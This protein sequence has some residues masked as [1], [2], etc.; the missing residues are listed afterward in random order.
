MD[1]PVPHVKPGD[2]IVIKGLCSGLGG[3]DP[4]L[5]ILGDVYITRATL[6]TR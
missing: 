1:I 5:G 2:A 6:I 3:G 4:D